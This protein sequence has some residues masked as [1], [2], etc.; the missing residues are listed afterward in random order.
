MTVW[1][2]INGSAIG[3][4]TPTQVRP[5][6]LVELVRPL[7]SGALDFKKSSRVHWSEDASRTL[8]RAL[9]GQVAAKY[10]KRKLNHPPPL[11]AKSSNGN[12]DEGG[13][14]DADVSALED[15][16]WEA[17]AHEVGNG[18]SKDDCCREFLRMPIDVDV[19]VNVDP[20]SSSSSS[21]VPVQKS[22]GDAAAMEIDN[23]AAPVSVTEP[24]NGK[25]QPQKR[26][27]AVLNS[28]R[29]DV[30]RELMQG[31]RPEVI[32]AA[33]NAAFRATDDIKEAQKATSLAVIANNAMESVK[34]DEATVDDLMYEVLNQRMRKL[35]RRADFLDDAEGM[36]EAERVALELERRDLYAMR[37]RH[38]LGD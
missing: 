35:E 15:I 23:Q 25:E 3:E 2:M 17:V 9:V 14:E 38:W 33:A 16:D 30:I 34:E 4:S 28:T 27:S 6:G 24:T 5:E 12:N 7:S 19:N 36:L 31:V 11:T 13:N 18:A 32:Q 10:K 20:A 1:G 8:T 21:C 26:T 37:C 29:E 22:N